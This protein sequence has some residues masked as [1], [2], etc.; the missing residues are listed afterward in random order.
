MVLSDKKKIIVFKVW[1]YND[2]TKL[3]SNIVN[4]FN[5][6]ADCTFILKSVSCLEY[7]VN[8]LKK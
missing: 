7:V 6:F 4:L 8:D 2:F 3:F 1:T 5:T